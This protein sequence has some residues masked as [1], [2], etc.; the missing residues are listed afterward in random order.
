MLDI[1]LLV[2]LVYQLYS[3]LTDTIILRA[4]VGFSLLVLAHL[5]AGYA[6]LP[7]LKMI[8]GQLVDKGPLVGIIVFQKE[9]RRLFL[10]IGETAT[11]RVGAL[12]FWL[13]GTEKA[14]KP[15]IDVASI[16]EA[17]KTLAGS[18]TGA[19]I[20]IS[21][22]DPLLSYQESGEPIE[23]IVSKRLLLAIFN[24]QSPLH[25]GAV[26]IYDNKIV[27][28]RSILPVTERRDVPAHLGLRHRAA[29]GMTEVTDVLV[30][31][32]SEET[33]QISSARNGQIASNLSTQE[34]RAAMYDYL[35]SKIQS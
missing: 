4:I 25:D 20:I 29:I 31:I 15:E 14:K 30:L 33:G 26:I 13:S 5:F 19:L 16:V 10:W 28:A 3:L 6:N 17:A 23:A 1:A 7:L 12:L 32:I 9:I 35:Q 18:N 11:L 22:K 24:K 8:L 34:T 21:Q 2:L 27:S